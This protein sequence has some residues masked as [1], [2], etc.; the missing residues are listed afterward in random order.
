MKKPSK[1]TMYCFAALIIAAFPAQKCPAVDDG[2]FQY[3]SINGV[4]FD[5]DNNWTFTFDEE[6][7]FSEGGTNLYYQHSDFG[8]VYKNFADNVD[9][10]F[11]FRKVFTKQ[12]RG[13][14]NSE[15]LPHLNITL[16]GRLFDLAVSNRSRFEYRDIDESENLFRYRNKFTINIPLEFTE[17]KLK[18]YLADEVFINFDEDGLNTNRLYSGL[19]YKFSKNIS[20]SIFHLWQLRKPTGQGW[21]ENINAIGTQFRIRF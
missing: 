1:I 2:D 9:L 20:G 17:L 11:N 12:G 8:L 10:G 15:N 16:K 7:R 21:G 18:P 19:S 5:I 14:W 13:E 6:L 3:W 4:S